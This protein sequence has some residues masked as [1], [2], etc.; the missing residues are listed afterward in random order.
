MKEI[1][2]KIVAALIAASASLL[3]TICS[4][5]WNYVSSKKR[6]KEI[7]ILKSQLA[8]RAAEKD[9]RRDYL[10]EAR[11][12][13]YN[14]CEPL[15]FQLTETSENFLHRVYSLARSSRKCSIKENCTGWLSD[16]GYYLASTIY[17]LLSPLAIFRLIQ[18]RLTLIDLS[19]DP[20]VQTQY[21]LAKQLYFAFTDDFEFARLEPKIPYNP[22]VN[23][24][25][26]KRDLNPSQFWRQG[27]PI[28]LLDIAVDSMLISESENNLRL[29]NFGEFEK[30]FYDD[31]KV[32]KLKSSLSA[33]GKKRTV[34]VA[35][36]FLGFHP[37]TRPVL[38]RL[39]ITQAR[40]CMLLRKVSTLKMEKNIPNLQSFL[41]IPKEQLNYFEWRNT[42]DICPDTE[43]FDIPFEISKEYIIKKLD[44][45]FNC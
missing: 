2:S 1:D 8:E 35:D 33:E 41:A 29:K 6:Q 36:I 37:R 9:A 4:L 28:G 7:E 14:E 21:Y 3:G 31:L 19:V 27:F 5:I 34:L 26:R 40:I 10:Y 13:L 20:R 12:R 24:W 38:W 25:S 30:D 17:N 23:D 22:N 42:S 43:V 16:R 45:L 44:F 32:T 15:L 18:R 39:L 11:K